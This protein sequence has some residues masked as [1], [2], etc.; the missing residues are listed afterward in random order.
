MCVYVCMCVC[1]RVYVCVCLCVCVSACA[2]VRT[3][4]CVCDS[5][6]LFEKELKILTDTPFRTTMHPSACLS[7]NQT[8][9][10]YWKDAGLSN[11]FCRHRLKS[12]ILFC[13]IPISQSNSTPVRPSPQSRPL[14]PTLKFTSSTIWTTWF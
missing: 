4:V 12:C 2:C 3:C 11:S 7:D 13:S 9:T 6:R 8:D 14:S 1:A 5:I 10:T